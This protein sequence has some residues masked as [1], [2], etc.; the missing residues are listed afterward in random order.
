MLKVQPVGMNN[1]S[2]QKRV[3]PASKP[4]N[5]NMQQVSKS[6]TEIVKEQQ[7]IND[8]LSKIDAHLRYLT[9]LCMA[10]LPASC[11]QDEDLFAPDKNPQT[12]EATRTTLSKSKSME[13][14]NLSERTDEILKVLGVFGDDNSIKDAK[15]IHYRDDNNTQYWYKPT[16]IKDNA[17]MGNAMTILRDDSEGEKYSFIIRNSDNNGIDF[18]KLYKNGDVENLNYRIDDNDDIIESKVLDNGFKLETS[19]YTK[20]EDGKVEQTFVGGD[21]KVYGGAQIDLPI[22]APITFD[23]GVLNFEDITY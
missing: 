10:A 21:K 23:A 11:T 8:N 9:I 20:R 12:T 19:K 16:N 5:G 6:N 15:T 18:I 1:V 7:K 2:F 4:A 22:P 13:T 14:K 3:G 17:I